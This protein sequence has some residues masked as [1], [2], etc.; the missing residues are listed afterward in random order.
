E[1]EEALARGEGVR[2]Q[3]EL[4]L[5]GLD[6]V[7]RKTVGI[8]TRLD[9]GG[10]RNPARLFLDRLLRSSLWHRLPQCF[11][12]QASNMCGGAIRARRWRLS[13]G[14]GP[15]DRSAAVLK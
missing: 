10:A 8:P 15:G 7:E 6:L 3:D 9:V 11:F 5:E 13:K 4:A 14:Q 12:P 1:I 2:P